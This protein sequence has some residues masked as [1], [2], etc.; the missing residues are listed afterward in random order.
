MSICHNSEKRIVFIRLFCMTRKLVCRFNWLE[1]LRKLCP[2]TTTIVQFYSGK[3]QCTSGDSTTRQCMPG[4]PTKEAVREAELPVFALTVVANVWQV[5]SA[6]ESRGWEGAEQPRWA[7]WWARC[8]RRRSP[9]VNIFCLNCESWWKVSLK[10]T[11]VFSFSFAFS[12]TSF[13][14]R[15]L[16]LD[17]RHIIHFSP[18]SHWSKQTAG[19]PKQSCHSIC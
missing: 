2:T 8:L 10:F 14:K 16:L 3:E 6:T 17:R 13:Q 5:K 12:L 11:W 15:Q 1:E 18:L 9:R 7:A 4:P 19:K